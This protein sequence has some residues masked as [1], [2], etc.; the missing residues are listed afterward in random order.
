MDTDNMGILHPTPHEFLRRVG[1]IF[2]ASLTSGFLLGPVRGRLLLCCC[3]RQVSVD[4]KIKKAP[5]PWN[6]G[7][8][9]FQFLMKMY[10]SWSQ[11]KITGCE[12]SLS[13]PVGNEI[14]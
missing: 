4:Q 1:D 5:R 11:G 7:L 9:V 3:V 8:C 12:Q 2:P 14:Y 10:R 13:F 6:M